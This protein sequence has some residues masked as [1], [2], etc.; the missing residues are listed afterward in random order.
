M[1]E[2][3]FKETPS[4][5]RFRTPSFFLTLVSST[6]KLSGRVSPFRGVPTLPELGLLFLTGEHGI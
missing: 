3:L 4:G 1:S 6:L 2:T 5:R